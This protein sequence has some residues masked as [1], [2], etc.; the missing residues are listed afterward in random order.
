MN[1]LIKRITF[2]LFVIGIII[3]AVI[4]NTAPADEYTVTYID[5]GQ[6]DSAVVSGD[7]TNILIDAGTDKNARK[8]KI[9]LD[10][11]KIKTLDLVVLSHLDSDHI[12]G[13]SELI[14]SFKVKKVITGKIG[15]K[16]LPGSP[17]LDELKVALDLNKI[18]FNMVKAGDKLKLNNIGLSVLSPNM[19]YGESNEDSAVVML[20]CGRKELLFTGDINSKVE[21]N[22]LDK[23]IDADFLKV[24]HHGSFQATSEEFLNAVNPSYAVVSVSQFN[25]YNLPNVEVMKRLYGYGCKVFR[26][27]E[28]GSITFHIN[29]NGVK[30]ECEK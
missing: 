20:N 13:M 2:V 16:Y 3:T 9:A 26:T 27:D 14:N 29:G 5:V 21:K 12:S 6:G 22:L 17:S 7:N 4:M 18:P 10:R 8:V 11:L 25:T 23:D 15:K 30:Y 24:A 19:E 28:M 1:R